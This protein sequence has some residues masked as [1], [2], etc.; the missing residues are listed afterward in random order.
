M[1]IL[2]RFLPVIVLALVA[3][4]AVP[5][6]AA[7]FKVGWIDV[8]QVL[9]SSSQGQA[10]NKVIEARAQDYKKKFSA[11]KVKLDAMKK[12]LASLK[13]VGNAD[14]I[15]SQERSLDRK[16]QELDLES[17]YA[18]KD[19][20]E[21]QKEKLSPVIDELNKVIVELGHSGDYDYILDS[22]TLLFAGERNNITDKAIA[23]MNKRFSATAKK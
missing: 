15:R 8:Q 10:A 4:S 2:S 16:I 14:A 19:M 9:V 13:T 22:R 3:L 18:S 1:K 5:S 6:V 12:K 7:D 23:A 17:K 21:L 11:A 20:K